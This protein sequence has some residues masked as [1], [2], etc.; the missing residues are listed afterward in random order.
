MVKTLLIQ[1]FFQQSY[2]TLAGIHAK[3]RADTIA[4]DQ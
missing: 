3:S 4:N 1:P 2:P